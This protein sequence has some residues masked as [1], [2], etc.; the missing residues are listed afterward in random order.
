VRP[1]L[2]AFLDLVFPPR[3]AACGVLGQEPFCPVCAEAVDPAPP[4]CR[5]CGRPGPDAVCGACLVQPPAFDAVRSG[6]L[7]GGPLAD[8]VHALKYRGR[9]AL[10]RPLGEWLARRVE[11]PAAAA[12][13]PVPLAPRRRRERGHDQAALLAEAL[14]RAAGRERL[15]RALRRVRETPPQV[16]R[17][18]AARAHNVQG[19]FAA[20][21]AVAGRDVVLVDDVVTTGATLSAC[22]AALLGAGAE[23]V[24]GLAVARER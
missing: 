6:G 2:R 22:A 13:V 14:A 3:C 23:V 10:A 15:R 20:S 21:T 19:A 1:T 5:R 12:V 16:G 24:S 7:L 17:D 8:A 11:L 4:G 9:P 18:R